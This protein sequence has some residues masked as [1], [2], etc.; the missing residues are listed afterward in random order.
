MKTIALKLINGIFIL[1][2]VVYGGGS[3]YFANVLI[4]SDTQTLAVS[5]QRIADLNYHAADLPQPE[6]VLIDTGEVSLA[7][8]FYD[9]AADGRCAVLMLHGYTSTR[10][11]VL[12]YAD[13][14]WQRG[15]DLLAYDARGHGQ[16][17]DAYHTY[18]YHEKF[19]GRAAYEWLLSKTGLPAEDVG[20]AGVSY[21]AATSLQMVPIL[22]NAAFIVADSA[23]QDLHTIVVHQAAEQFG[24][25]TGPFVPGAFFVAQLRAD[26][27]AD[28]V[29]PQNAVIGTNIPILLIHAQA[30][31]FTPPSHS[32]T[33]YTRSN[34]A[35]T[36][37]H[38]TPYG[39]A[40]ARSIIDDYE[41]Y[42]ELVDTFLDDK[43]PGFGLANGG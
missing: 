26:F 1:L 16:S 27:S 28:D 9:N 12:Q 6:V 13:P 32:E 7:G 37:L 38:L 14:F 23:Y 43:V 5:Q 39:T 17:S 15:C 42:K 21:G 30:D 22:P 10:Y 20:I 2:G 25:W 29:S 36:E 33:I 40:H 18:G 8:F 31:T 3:L 41:A 4:N 24:Q 34:P 19:D 11:G 35:T